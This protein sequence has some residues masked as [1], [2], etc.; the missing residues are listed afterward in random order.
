MSSTAASTRVRRTTIRAPPPTPIATGRGLRSAAAN[1]RVLT[2]FLDS[3]LRV[4]DLTLLPPKSPFKVINLPSLVAGDAASVRRMMASAAEAGA[5]LIA[6]WDP[7]RADEVRSAA[8]AARGVFEIEEGRRRRWFGRGNEFY[9]GRDVVGAEK[10]AVLK[11]MLT[12]EGYRIFREKMENMASRLETVAETITK[13]L[14]ENIRHKSQSTK[15]DQKPSV[16]C[17]RK[18]DKSHNN[19]GHLEGDAHTTKGHQNHMLSLLT[20][21]CHKLYLHSAEA[22]SFTL[23]AGLILVTI[24]EPFQEWSNGELKAYTGEILLESSKDQPAPI[25]LEFM[26]STGLRQELDHSTQTI[27]L[28]DQM[29]IM[30]VFLLLYKLCY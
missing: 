28:M 27:S 8:A 24:G 1:D 16:L 23:P 19:S 5:F 14:S 22:S 25:A 11:E 21:D 10:E 12:V 29:L 3:S 17:L 26:F 20:G 7:Q 18:Y 13:I 2:E 30:L 4:P 9:W 6:G 15:F